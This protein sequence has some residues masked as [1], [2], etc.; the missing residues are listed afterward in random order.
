M[1]NEPKPLT[2]EE[3]DEW[4]RGCSTITEHEGVTF[5]RRVIATIR[6]QEARI[7]ELEAALLKADEL[8]RQARGSCIADFYKAALEYEK[9]R[10]EAA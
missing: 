5:H 2:K 8:A 10:R 7:K 4:E 1:T 3:V 6:A 9:A